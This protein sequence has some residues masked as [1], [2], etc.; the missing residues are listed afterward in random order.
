VGK[1][2][3]LEGEAN[4]K[5]TAEA[6]DGKGKDGNDGCKQQFFRRDYEFSYLSIFTGDNN[7]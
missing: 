6:E 7:V 1:V 5:E 4:G 3:V 2:G